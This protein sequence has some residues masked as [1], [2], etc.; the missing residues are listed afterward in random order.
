MFLGRYLL[1]LSMAFN[2][3][4][5]VVL[6]GNPDMSISARAGYARARGAKFGTGVCHVLDW[7]DWH[8]GDAPEG[9]HC[10]KAVNHDISGVD[11]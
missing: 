6:G 10:Q 2:Q 5:N 8:D 7:L 4:A 3:L 1:S 9:D 11:D